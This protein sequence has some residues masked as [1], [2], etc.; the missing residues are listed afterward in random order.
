M[1]RRFVP[2]SVIATFGFIAGAS[3]AMAGQ[4]TGADPVPW[5]QPNRGQSA[6]GGGAGAQWAASDST[7]AWDQPNHVWSAQW[8]ALPAFDIKPDTTRHLA[9]PAFLPRTGQLYGD[10]ELFYGEGSHDVVSPSGAKYS[11]NA[12]NGNAIYQKLI[13]GVTDRISLNASGGHA[14][15]SSFV[16]WYDGSSA[17]YHSSGFINP[18]IGAKYR[19]IEQSS[20]PV[21]L[22]VSATYSPN[23]FSARSASNTKDGT[24]ASGG[25]SGGM[26]IAV[27]RQ[28]KSLT[29]LASAGVTYQ[30][31]RSSVSMYDNSTS[32]AGKVW[33]YNFGL[34]TQ[35]R[36]TDRLFLDAGANV[37]GGLTDE[38]VTNLSNGNASTF[39]PGTGISFSV[40]PGYYLI[41]DR[42]ALTATYSRPYSLSTS[43]GGSSY[44]VQN[45]VVDRYYVDLKYLFF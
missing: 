4:S 28:M 13:Y 31:E 23:M 8:A 15:G 24:E 30:G 10:T 35:A 45:D 44:T 43:S 14:Q 29:V 2:A 34:S 18:S 20:I 26:G 5:D 19:A 41:P 7:H 32:A 36:F 12:G 21:N 37:T 42:L 11:S 17:A 33:G 25:Q 9:D 39:S 40:S 16:T 27:S 22:D 1:R 6:Q 3:A 38:T